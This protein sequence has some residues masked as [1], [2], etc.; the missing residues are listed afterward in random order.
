[1]KELNYLYS[2][3]IYNEEVKEQFLQGYKENTKDSLRRIFKASY[4]MEKDLNKDLYNFNRD[5][6]RSFFY[7]MKPK[8]KKSSK[9]NVYLVKLYIEWCIENGFKNSFNPLENLPKDWSDQFVDIGSKQYFTDKELDEIVDGCVNAQDA[10]IVQLLREGVMGE[11]CEEL[12]N[13]K[14]SDIDFEN[15]QLVLRDTINK[16]ERIRT[17]SDKCIS[18][19]RQALNQTEYEKANGEASPNIK[20]PVS[21]LVENGHVIKPALTNTKSFGRAEKNIIHRRLDVLSDYFDLPNFTP[22]NI[23]YSGMLILAKNIYLEKGNLNDEDFAYILDTF[24]V[25]NTVQNEKQVY[26]SMRREFLNIEKIKELYN[27]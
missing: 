15:C 25:R 4:L 23:Y 17:V 1:M 5:E 18:L 16:T 20:S 11:G 2:G 24:G 12:L 7:M 21:K 26:Y 13:L 22:R 10:V 14:K 6:L 8:K 27:I 3:E 9:Q 19:C